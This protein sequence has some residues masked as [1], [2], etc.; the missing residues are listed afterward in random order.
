[1]D[2]AFWGRSAWQFL[3]SI[4][5]NYPTKPTNEDRIKYSNYFK[6][7]GDMLPCPTCAES[8]KI[9]MKYIPIDEYLDDI[10]GITIWLYYIHNIVNKK[11][12]KETPPFLD[13]INIYYPHKAQCVNTKVKIESNGVCTAKSAENNNNIYSEFKQIAEKKYLAKIL[14]QIKQLYVDNQI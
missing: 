4:S 11:L 2:P 1:M 9:Y 8:F 5:F 10:H 7:L 13:V 6:S 14:K 3:H 12:D